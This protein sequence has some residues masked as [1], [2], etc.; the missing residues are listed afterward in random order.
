LVA[1]AIFTVAACHRRRAQ[2]HYG[3]VLVFI[4]WQPAMGLPKTVFGGLRHELIS[5]VYIEDNDLYVRALMI[6]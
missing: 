6:E 4:D 5:M 2:L 3:Q 1:R